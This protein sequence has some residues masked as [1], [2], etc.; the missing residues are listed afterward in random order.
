MRIAHVALFC[1]QLNVMCTN[2]CRNGV[3]VAYASFVYNSAQPALFEYLLLIPSNFLLKPIPILFVIDTICTFQE[4][5][6]LGGCKGNKMTSPQKEYLFINII[7]NKY[8][9]CIGRAQSGEND[10]FVLL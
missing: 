3:T 5:S 6:Q 9:C 1:M 2:W 10:K 7:V 8:P 4:I